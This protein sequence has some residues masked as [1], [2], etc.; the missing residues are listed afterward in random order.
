MTATESQKM[1][2]RFPFPRPILCP[3]VY[4]LVGYLFSALASPRSR[5]IL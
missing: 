5:L 1:Q 4:L 2:T 3:L